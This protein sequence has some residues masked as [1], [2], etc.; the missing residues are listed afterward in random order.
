MQQ[1]TEKALSEKTVDWKKAETVLYQQNMQYSQLKKYYE[2]YAI[3]Q[4]NK[5][6][7]SKNALLLRNNHYFLNNL[8]HMLMQQ[9][10]AVQ[11]YQAIKEKCRIDWKKQQVKRKHLRYL[12]QLEWEEEDEE[13]HFMHGPK[14]EM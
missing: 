8:Q 11:K 13:A 6:K 12:K 9:R 4:K 5:D 10:T 7:Q 3:D 2:D 14:T 1:I